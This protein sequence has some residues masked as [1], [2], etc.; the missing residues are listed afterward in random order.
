MHLQKSFS[1]ILSSRCF[2]AAGLATV[3]KQPGIPGWVFE[4]G[5]L[6]ARTNTHQL[7]PQNT[8]GV[9][10]SLVSNF[11]TSPKFPPMASEENNNG[12]VGFT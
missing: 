5:L 4:A 3:W 12:G 6:W 10:L 8:F 7:R 11:A 2:E 9:K 1:E